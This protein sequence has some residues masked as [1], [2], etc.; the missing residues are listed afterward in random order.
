MNTDM[1]APAPV[2]KADRVGQ[3]TEVAK[4]KAMTE[5]QGAIWMA[6]QFPR[7]VE[8]ARQRML[9]ACAQPELADK[10]FFSYPRGDEEVKGLTIHAACELAVCW[11]N[12][13]YGLNEMR[14]DD[15]YGQSETL[16]WAWDLETNV[17]VESTFIAPHIREG[18]GGRSRRVTNSRDIYEVVTNQGNRRMRAAILKVLPRWY[19]LQAEAALQT[20]LRRMVESNDKGP[21]QRVAES[22][23]GFGKRFGVTKAQLEHKLGKSAEQWGTDDFV[24]LQILWG[25]LSRGDVST[26]E[27]FP[28]AKVT[29]EEIRGDAAEAAPAAEE[30]PSEES[31]AELAH[32]DHDPGALDSECPACVAESAAADQ[33]A[34]AES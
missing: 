25:S 20:T 4:A 29:A 23:A 9:M 33:K 14:R 26:E 6:R 10:A 16:A 15:E 11:G 3:A 24:K 34:Q 30:A 2:A 27:A 17:Q 22:L 21:E 31:E 19:K 5:A 7:D 13:K 1:F 32:T 12:I 18:K 28:D 8:A